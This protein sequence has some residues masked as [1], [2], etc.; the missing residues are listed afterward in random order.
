M[1]DFHQNRRILKSDYVAQSFMIF[2]FHQHPSC[3][4][5]GKKCSKFI[6]IWCAEAPALCGSNKPIFVIFEQK[7][8]I[9]M[10]S[11][12]H[13]K[14]CDFRRCFDYLTYHTNQIYWKIS[15]LISCSST[16]SKQYRSV[17]FWY[18]TRIWKWLDSCLLR[19]FFDDFDQ[20]L[21]NFWWISDKKY[22][23]DSRHSKFSKWNF[24]CGL[25]C[26]HSTLI[27]Y[28]YVKIDVNN[29]FTM[30]FKRKKSKT[31]I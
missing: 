27:M 11:T 18:K 21:I 30:V 24:A 6:K 13:V 23:F 9:F 28:W 22:H 1:Y 4:R 19:L 25:H 14:W 17:K 7:L 10:F 2:I 5:F 16:K 15:V 8:T 31:T 26:C 12:W 3:P 20:F 29:N